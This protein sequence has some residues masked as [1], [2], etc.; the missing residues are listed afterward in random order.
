MD[1]RSKTSRRTAGEPPCA[2]AW[3]RCL[4]VGGRAP[5]PGCMRCGVKAVSAAAARAGAD[6]RWAGAAASTVAGAT[7][8][9]RKSSRKKAAMA[10]RTEIQ[11][12]AA[13]LMG[14]TVP[15]LLMTTGRIYIR[16]P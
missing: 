4:I 3:I 2:S 5:S 7:S 13:R 16:S 6:V 11:N 9:G 14:M 12:D 10:S 15:R 1:D 8:G